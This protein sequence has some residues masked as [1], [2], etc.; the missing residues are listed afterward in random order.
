[1]HRTFKI[2]SQPIFRAK[3]GIWYKA[4]DR[5]SLSIADRI[6]RS[7]ILEAEAS[8]RAIGPLVPSHSSLK[9]IHAM[10][11]AAP[12]ALGTPERAAWKDLVQTVS[13]TGAGWWSGAGERKP[14]RDVQ[15]N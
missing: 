15:G 1:M 13:R 3:C 6:G 2:V 4:E 10:F 8:A 9:A 11:M 7:P 12:L 14:S 5:E